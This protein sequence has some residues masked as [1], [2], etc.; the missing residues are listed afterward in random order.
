MMARKDAQKGRRG[1]NDAKTPVDRLTA[2]AGR[3]KPTGKPGSLRPAPITWQTARCEATAVGW[4]LVLPV[5]VS[6]NRI[7]RTGR[8]RTFEAKQHRDDKAAVALK[9]GRCGMLTGDVAVRVEWVRERRAGDV[10]NFAGKPL[11]DW[12]KGVLFEDDKQVAELHLS[13]HDDPT[14]APGLYVDV[15]TITNV[16]EAA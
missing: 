8:G 7:W 12:L 9:F 3:R 13:R 10:D 14:R 2:A 5:P 1:P 11:L 15:W 4:R 16:K 6:A